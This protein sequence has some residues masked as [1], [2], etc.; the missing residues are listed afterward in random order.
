M[1]ACAL[2]PVDDQF[3][4]TVSKE[5]REIVE[6]RAHHPSII[7]WAGNN[8]NEV[9][10]GNWWPSY[11]GER[12]DYI[13]LYKDTI[14]TIVNEID[15]SR[16]YLLSS[17][18]NGIK[19]EEDGGLSSIPQDEKYGDIHYYNDVS[20][21]WD[22][23]SF[24]IPR[25]ASEYGVQSFPQKS[26]LFRYLN[27]SDEYYFGSPILI[28]RQHHLA[29]DI[30][31]EMMVLNHFKPLRGLANGTYLSRFSF[32][33]QIHQAI[34]MERQTNHYLSWRSKFDVSGRG[35]TSCAM[36]WQL[37][38]V[39]AGPTWSSID[40]DLRWKPVM[41]HAKRFFSDVTII[42]NWKKD[43]MTLGIMNDQITAIHN[44]TL[45]IEA[46][47]FN[48]GM[49]PIYSDQIG[50]KIIPSLSFLDVPEPQHKPTLLNEIPNKLKLLSNKLAPKDEYL[51]TSYLLSSTNAKLTPTAYLYPN[52][53]FNIPT[54]NTALKIK[55]VK[56]VSNSI[57]TI[58]LSCNN[59]TPFVWLDITDKI[60]EKYPRLVFVFSDNS[61][62]MLTGEKVVKL[63]IVH[64]EDDVVLS[65]DDINICHLDNCGI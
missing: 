30:T 50:I 13:K 53:F 14:G 56:I 15:G 11:R 3:I 23:E 55:S 60:K 31:L 16:P 62:V 41:Y 36:I 12:E 5:I 51:I 45:V 1:F 37:N 33:T 19:T 25:C 27:S 24:Q 42:M 17:P 39:W 61:F 18:S 28:S 29:G 52:K 63:E 21:L 6:D 49:D 43:D 8:E 64:N 59:I 2:Y 32:L 46:F 34:A 9:A 10:I 58:T 48:S 35:K 20:D 54:I 22:I 47:A 40:F 7:A 38:D 44:T 4:E 65:Q 57:Y 26:T